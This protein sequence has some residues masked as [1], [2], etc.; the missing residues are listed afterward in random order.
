MGGLMAVWD[1]SG[2]HDAILAY[3]N[4]AGQLHATIY[5]GYAPPTSPFPYAVFEQGES[6]VLTRSTGARGDSNAQGRYII[7]VPVTF[8]IHAQQSSAVSA[9]TIA[10][11]IGEL[12]LKQFGGSDQTAAVELCLDA[13]AVLI[14]QYDTDF[15]VR[16]GDTEWSY[17]LRFNFWIDSPIAN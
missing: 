14:S 11:A 12:L 4:D 2:I 16:E 7:E 1:S 3:R 13:G 15:F 9:K 10:A 5:E 17:V 6:R 8:R